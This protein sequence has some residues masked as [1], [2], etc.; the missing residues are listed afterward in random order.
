MEDKTQFYRTVTVDENG[1]Q[2]VVQHSHPHNVD[3]HLH[4]SSV[5]TS[6]D[7]IVVDISNTGYTNGG[8]TN[9]VH[10]ENFWFDIDADN[11]AD[12]SMSLGYLKDV[13]GSGGTFVDLYTVSGSK[14]A[15]QSRSVFFPMYP[16]GA[17]MKN[18]DVITVDNIEEA[19]FGSGST[20]MSTLSPYSATVNPGESDVV[21]RIIMNAGSLGLSLNMSYHTH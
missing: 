10:V 15:G 19:S 21:L 3:V 13:V 18:G 2:D 11:T 12:Y 17:K 1:R 6:E 9:Y 14:K 4:L 5:T 16:N 7:Y 20:M 8:P